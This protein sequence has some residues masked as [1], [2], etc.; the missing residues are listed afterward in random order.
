MTRHA[1]IIPGGTVP[2]TGGTLYNRR[3]MRAL[4]HTGHDVLEHP[5]TAAW[6]LPPPDE[7]A[8]LA[9]ALSAL[10]AGIPL[11]V[12]GLLWTGLAPFHNALVRAHDC[13]VL[14]HSPLFRETGLSSKQVQALHQAEA[15][16]LRTAT[17][18][19]AT[20]GPTRRD[21]AAEFGIVAHEVPPG[22]RPCAHVPAHDPFQLLCV[23]TL[24]PRKGHD[25]LLRG[26]AQVMDL[27]W[28]LVCAGSTTV[29]P[30]W[31]RHIQ[32]LVHTL[33]LT[34]RVQ[35][36]G[37]LGRTELDRV[38]GATGVL[39]HTARYEAWGMALTE[40]LARGIPVVSTPA[41]ALEGPVAAAAH[42]LPAEP[43]D[44][45]VAVAIRSVL[46]MQ[47]A[48][49]RAVARSLQLPTWADRA[50]QLAAVLSTERSAQQ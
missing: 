32:S 33:K 25:R 13:S 1:W 6:P 11:V 42:L 23:A 10:P 4:R 15:H 31:F 43:T 26:L 50:R 49:L 27:P 16:A 17:R 44:A 20:G 48:A 9:R 19:I 14:V 38:F 3:I 2:R 35:F 24:T 34:H 46:E 29:D 37:E 28:S 30:T 18:C 40:A 41:G 12:D 39:V 36:T 7:Q 5:L 47:H 8:A 45:Q 22:V 21:L